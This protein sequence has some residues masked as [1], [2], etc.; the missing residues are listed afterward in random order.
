MKAMILTFAVLLVCTLAHAEDAAPN[1]FENPV[2]KSALHLDERKDQAAYFPPYLSY[3]NSDDC[4]V[5]FTADDID[6]YT[7]QGDPEVKHLPYEV[8]RR[9]GGVVELRR[10]GPYTYVPSCR[11]FCGS[12]KAYGRDTIS[13][14]V[15]ENG[16]ITKAVRDYTLQTYIGI[17]VEQ[18]H[19]ECANLKLHKK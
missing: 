17:I 4:F 8:K 18:K 6:F 12:G 2:L 10:K 16:D 14:T 3:I 11:L 19:Y 7:V 13:L 9:A 5:R 1:L 15:D